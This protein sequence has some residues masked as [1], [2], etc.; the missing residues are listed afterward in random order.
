MPYSAIDPATEYVAGAD[1]ATTPRVGDG[2]QLWRITHDG[3][4]SHSIH[5][6]GFS[7]QVLARAT[8]DGDEARA[9]DPGE[10]GWKDTLRIDP[11]ETCLVA[12]R[13]VL[14]QLPFKLAASERPLDVT[15]P[16]GATGGFTELDPVTAAPHTVVERAGRL[17][18]GGRRGASTCPAARRATRCGRWSSRAALRLPRT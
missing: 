13:P 12:L 9:P 14:P 4:E 5:F 8:R 3:I 6:G 11:L 1:R 16:L 2:T 10:L 17:Q 7:V 15:R 18:L